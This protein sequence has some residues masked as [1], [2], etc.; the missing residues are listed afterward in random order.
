[1]L[2]MF[3]TIYS[4]FLFAHIFGSIIV[5]ALVGSIF[6][7]TLR[8]KAALYRNFALSL[9]FA[10]CYQLMTGSLLALTASGS[11]S[12]FSFCSKIGIYLF[13]ILLA[14]MLLFMKMKKSESVL[15]PVRAVFSSITGG[16]I[17][18]VFAVF[19]F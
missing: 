4:L 6:Y 9:G 11:H 17:F 1:M 15:F 14:E 16:I 10:S 2:D 13:F 8:N 3:M 19:S 12:L 7:I 5:A 18:V